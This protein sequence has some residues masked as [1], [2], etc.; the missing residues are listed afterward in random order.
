LLCLFLDREDGSSTLLRNVELH[1]I[2]TQKII[3]F[4]AVM[5]LCSLVGG[6]QSFGANCCLHLQSSSGN[7]QAVSI[8]SVQI[9]GTFV[10]CKHMSIT[11]YHKIPLKFQRK[12][13]AVMNITS[14][15]IVFIPV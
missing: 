13:N 1:G 7:D 6:Y 10:F 4:K 3:L 11:D 12:I 8:D 5:I 14:S 2:P 9:T 15:N